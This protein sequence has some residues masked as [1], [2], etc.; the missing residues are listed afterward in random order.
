MEKLQGDLNEK[1]FFRN[2]AII[3][4]LPYTSISYKDKK[5]KG[6]GSLEYTK[7]LVL[8]IL[9]KKEN[10]IVLVL[11]GSSKWV[12]L[13][14]DEYDLKT[15]NKVIINKNRSQSI[16]PSNLGVENFENICKILRNNE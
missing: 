14:K 10:N 2:V 9:E 5:Y 3:Q 8:E 12:A 4:Y 16:S 1:E 13:L 6:I 15:S 11:R 7:K